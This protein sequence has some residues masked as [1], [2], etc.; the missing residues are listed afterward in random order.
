[1]FLSNLRNE[2]YRKTIFEK[3]TEC[4][5]IKQNEINIR[6]KEIQVIDDMLRFVN[7]F[8]IKY[9]NNQL[10]SDEMKNTNTEDITSSMFNTNSDLTVFDNPIANTIDQYCLQIDTRDDMPMDPLSSLFSSSP[11]KLFSGLSTTNDPIQDIDYLK[12]TTNPTTD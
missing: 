11:T 9:S 8:H 6:Q 4:R 7:E 5:R 1:S 2:T 3:L 10:T 12:S